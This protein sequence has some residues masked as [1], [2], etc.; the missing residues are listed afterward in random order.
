MRFFILFFLF[1]YLFEKYIFHPEKIA[2][3]YYILILTISKSS[4]LYFFNI[5]LYFPA[6]FCLSGLFF[7]P[8]TGISPGIKEICK[9]ID[10]DKKEST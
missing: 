4:Y 3:I 7:Q 9:K 2:L 5:L 6:N 10:K 8:D 1:F